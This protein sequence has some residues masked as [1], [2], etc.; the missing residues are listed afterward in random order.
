LVPYYEATKSDWEPPRP[1]AKRT[2][3][4]LGVEAGESPGSS[5]STPSGS[6]QPP[7]DQIAPVTRPTV[8]QI[9]YELPAGQLATFVD[10]FGPQVFLIWKNVLAQKRILFFAPPPVLSLNHHGGLVEVSASDVKVFDEV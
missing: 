1:K 5:S 4:T 3:E 6:P 10:Y 7:D 8:P 2:E 9:L